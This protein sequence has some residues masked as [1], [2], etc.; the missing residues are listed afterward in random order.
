MK[1]E[2]LLE[3]KNLKT[4]FKIGKKWA[5]A[6]NGIS[7]N[8][9]KGETLGIVGESGSG[10]SVS[11]LSL[12]QLIPNPPGEVR[13]GSIKFNGETLFDGQE[14][15]AI[16]DKP[17]FRFFHDLNGKKR[18][19]ATRGFFFGWLLLHILL[20]IPGLLTFIF[21]FVLDAVIT[22]KL[23]FSSPRKEAME[24]YR[25]SMY[26]KM[27]EYRGREIA[28][29]FQEPMTSLNPVFTVGMQVI[30]S[31]QP[32]DFWDY[33]KAHII[34]KAKSLS[35]V[36]MKNRWRVT[37]L[38]AFF[39]LVISQL[40]AGWTFQI[41]QIFTALLIGGL[42]PTTVA[43]LYLGLNKLIPDR[44][45]AEHEKL[46]QGGV[47]LLQR[48]GI[49]D[50]EKRLKDYPHQFSGGMRQ[51]VMIAMA[52]AKN[53]SLLIA[54]EPTTALDVTIQAQILDLMVDLKKQNEDAAIVLITHDLAVIAETCE[55]VIVMY[56]G[57]I[58]EV[59]SVEELFHNPSHPY[60]IGLINSIPRPDKGNAKEKLETIQGMV[61][62]ILDMPEGCKFCTRCDL[63]EEKCKSEDPELIDVG[64]DHF[65]RCHF[66]DKVIEGKE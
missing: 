48:V 32:K 14:L 25:E 55:R 7:F 35:I 56:G 16:R 51:R 15:E 42:V 29:I 11:V 4:R 17:E 6:V 44:E 21:S 46:L 27:R 12:I 65:V 37:G 28:M 13:E 54:D 62:N 24:K 20:G 43:F 66:L 5:V 38:T 36:S 3:I 64:K 39:I 31:I 9:L 59:A 19:W 18:N 61:P 40:A 33:V 30:E 53:P 45:K 60:T 49:P 22:I 41:G 58:Q 34:E 8:I 1:R 26:R 50:A 2:P 52:L 47:E 57:K 63:A 10:K 23:F